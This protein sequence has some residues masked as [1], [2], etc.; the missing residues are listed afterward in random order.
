MIANAYQDSQNAHAAYRL[1]TTTLV[2]AF[3]SD[4]KKGLCTE[5][6]HI[7][8]QH[9]GKNALPKNHCGDEYSPNSGPPHDMLV[10]ILI[11]LFVWW[12]EHESPF[13]YES[14]TIFVIVLFNGILGFFQEYRADKAM[15]ALQ[16]MEATTAQ[17]LRDGEI[18]V[19]ATAQIVPGD[20]L[21]I[22]EGDI[23]AADARTGGHCIAPD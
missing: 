1:P 11:S 3:E 8:L 21:L 18:Q 9:Y 5:E 20:I 23:I 6:A 17:V 10:A 7:R 15:V 22:E 12:I 19:V 13:P 2:T 16:A 4:L 14:L